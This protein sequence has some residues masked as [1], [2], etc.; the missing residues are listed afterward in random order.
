MPI[1]RPLGSE[2]RFIDPADG[3]ENRAEKFDSMTAQEVLD[4]VGDDLT[5]AQKALSYEQEHQQRK[6]LMDDLQA[7]LGVGKK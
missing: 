2:P 3:Y 4:W 5:R 6:G 7:I 1:R